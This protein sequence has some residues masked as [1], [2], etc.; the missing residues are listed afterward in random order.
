M[1]KPIRSSSFP[2]PFLAID[3]PS[4]V[5]S[6]RIQGSSY[7]AG[8]VWPYRRIYLGY[9]FT[10]FIDIVK[11]NSAEKREKYIVPLSYWRG[12]Q[13]SHRFRARITANQRLF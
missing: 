6:V 9:K 12:F 10:K 7:G 8:L 13:L 11:F 5:L 4:D 1:F 2:S 3:P